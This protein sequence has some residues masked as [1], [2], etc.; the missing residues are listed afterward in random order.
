MIGAMRTLF[1]LA[2][3]LA[4][5]ID[6]ERPFEDAEPDPDAMPA[7]ADVFVAAPPDA[8]TPDAALPCLRVAPAQIDFGAVRVGGAQTV[9]ADLENCG[10]VPVRIHAVRLGTGDGVFGVPEGPAAIEPGATAGLD[11][12][13]TPRTAGTFRRAL[14]VV[15]D[16]GE[17]TIAMTGVG[18]ACP[19]VRES[20]ISLRAAPLDV[21]PLDARW[22]V[23]AGGQAAQWR[24]E[25][26]DAARPTA[27]LEP[28]SNLDRPREV[29]VPDDPRTPLAIF[30]AGEPGFYRFDLR[31]QLTAGGLDFPSADC[32]GE[33]PSVGVEVRPVGALRVELGWTWPGGPDPDAPGG[34]DLDLHLLHPAA[35]AWNAAPFDAFAQNPSPDWGAPRVP[36]DNPALFADVMDGARP[37]ALF[38][39]ALEDTT[40]FGRGYWIG[41]HAFALE[42]HNDGGTFAPVTASVRVW[43]GGALACEL[44]RDLG[45]SG[46]LWHVAAVVTTPTGPECRPIDTLHRG[47]PSIEP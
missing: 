6:D 45:G 44:R 16:T 38:L 1:A 39:D 28:S 9:R 46:E 27:L 12:I 35:E 22:L 8:A 21:V 43:L 34:P 11:V 4:G 19:A 33:P 31:V 24:W 20:R 32:P 42:N 17:S 37:E 29:G 3:L 40:A 36:D 25:V 30:V 7:A 5:C 26:A 14:I 41:A 15:A 13:F 18:V 10:A 47:F 2:L 23:D